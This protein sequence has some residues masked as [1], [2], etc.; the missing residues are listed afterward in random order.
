MR[1]TLLNLQIFADFPDIFL[2]FISGLI[3]VMA[4]EHT[5]RDFL[6]FLI[7]SGLFYG[8]EYGHVLVNGPCTLRKNVYFAH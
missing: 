2:L 6:V 1:S 8:L 7:C 3:L 5:L 4:R